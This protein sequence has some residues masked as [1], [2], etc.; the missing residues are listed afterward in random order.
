MP[1]KSR[2]FD[3]KQDREPS[4]NII[5]E[6]LE[7]SVPQKQERK[8]PQTLDV[9]FDGNSISGSKLEYVSTDFPNRKLVVLSENSKVIPNLSKSYRVQVLRDTK[10]G[11]P[12]EGKLIVKILSETPDE[13]PVAQE[14]ILPRHEEAQ[15]HRA[16]RIRQ[17]APLQVALKIVRRN[18][19]IYREML[20]V[21]RRQEEFKKNTALEGE[22]HRDFAGL[23]SA[24]HLNERASGILNE[25][26][27]RSVRAET[28]WLKERLAE[29]ENYV[30]ELVIGTGVQSAA[31]R[32]ERLMYFPDDPGM[33]VDSNSTIGGQFSQS[34]DDVHF[35]NSRTRPEDIQLKNLPGTKGSINSMGRYAMSQL[36]DSS[37]VAYSSNWDLAENVRANQIVIGRIAVN[38]EALE[39]V[40]NDKQ[41]NKTAEVK[42][43]LMDTITGEEF[44]MFADRVILPT[45][46]GTEK[47]GLDENDPE[48]KTLVRIAEVDRING[49]DPKFYKFSWLMQRIGDKTEPF[50]L[51]GWKKVITWGDGDGF[52][53]AA[54]AILGYEGQVAKTVAQLDRIEEVIAI[55]QEFLTKEKFIECERARYHQLGLEF[56]REEVENY[57]SRIKPYKGKVLRARKEG[58]RI[59]V[60]A[61]IEDQ[62]G[63]G[64]IIE[65]EGDHA[66][67]C[68]GFKDE[69]DKLVAKNYQQVFEGK[70]ALAPDVY[71]KLIKTPG[72]IIETQ[73]EKIEIF[74]SNERSVRYRVYRKRFSPEQAARANVSIRTVTL[75]NFR[76][77]FE[78]INRDINRITVGFIPP[79]ELVYDDD[80]AENPD[81]IAVQYP[82][83][84]VQKIGPGAKLPI[85]ENEIQEAPVLAKIQE[86]SVAIF[87]YS[88]RKVAALARKNAKADLVKGVKPV[89]LS[90]VQAEKKIV[91]LPPL[92]RSGFSGYDFFVP[93]YVAKKGLPEGAVMQDML[94]LVVGEKAAQYRFPEGLDEIKFHITRQNLDPLGDDLGGDVDFSV[95]IEPKLPS[96]YSELMAQIFNDDLMRRIVAQLTNPNISMNSVMSVDITLPIEVTPDGSRVLDIGNISYKMPRSSRAS[97]ASVVKA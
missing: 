62:K 90:K 53:V 27:D 23:F 44:K 93:G 43:K 51:K 12:L 8:K 69:T 18:P 68:A 71:L 61:L 15:F 25:A 66:I 3:Q 92:S 57:Y 1:E 11:N 97:R 32:L 58:E 46:I 52:K 24:L 38:M 29:G 9:F 30:H 45:G 54:G 35:L 96:K 42:V 34:G 4:K 20:Q 77:Y 64:E 31:Y 83:L 36:S 19:D 47:S 76:D 67:A 55:G 40:R 59:I 39:I 74:P 89:G 5:G 85:T 7:R 65:F 10:P 88:N 14:Q 37:G 28:E 80:R 95:T 91:K 48:S 63:I 86:N 2:F 26:I 56:P 73:Y 84:P 21:L 16:E 75:A 82:G 50:P 70:D 13:K 78:D 17:M 79:T 81:P 22:R 33:A 72:S 6:G 60:E 49:F 94:N 87:R 41:E